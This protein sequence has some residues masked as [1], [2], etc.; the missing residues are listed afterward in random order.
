MKRFETGA[1]YEMRFIG[2]SELKPL[3]TCIKRTAKTVT[4][5]RVDGSETLN[6]RI[7]E[8]DNS[9]YILEGNYSMAPSIRAKN[10]VV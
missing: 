2:D 4:F 9:E 8:Y 6:R 5:Q 3:F 1:N 7:K 10:I